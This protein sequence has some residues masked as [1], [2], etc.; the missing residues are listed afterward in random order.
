MIHVRPRTPD[1]LP[2]LG[3]VLAAQAVESAYPIRWPWSGPIEEFIVRRGEEQAWTAVLADEP[4]RPVGHVSVVGVVDDVDD[5]IASG[6][7]AATGAPCEQLACIS[8]LFVDRTLRGEGIGAALLDT[9]TAWIQGEGRIPVLDVV[10]FH[11]DVID[12]Y[13]RRGWSEV[14]VAEPPW[15]PEATLVLMVLQTA[16]EPATPPGTMEP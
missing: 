15:L 16:G 11:E 13:R 5:G 2:V 4:D 10:S 9:A 14:G 8:V 1:D 7:M 12:L 6:W 3:E